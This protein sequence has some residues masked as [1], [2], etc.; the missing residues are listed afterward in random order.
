MTH[1]EWMRSTNWPPGFKSAIY[2][3]P[4]TKRF[5]TDYSRQQRHRGNGGWDSHTISQPGNVKYVQSGPVKMMEK[6]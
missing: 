3:D 5:E 1:T 4:R 2:V 6:P